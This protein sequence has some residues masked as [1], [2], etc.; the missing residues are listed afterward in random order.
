MSIESL[1]SII[2]RGQPTDLDR[3]TLADR[4]REAVEGLFST[5]YH[6]RSR[7]AARVA[8]MPGADAVSFAGLVH[9]DSPT[10]GV[11]GGMSLV[12]FPVEGDGERAAGSLLTFVC[13]TRGLAPDE[14]I[15]G[16]PGHA[17]HLQALRRF[18]GKEHGA[19]AWVKH[20]PT[21]LAEPF[22]N[23]AEPQPRLPPH[24]NPPPQGGRGIFWESSSGGLSSN[25]PSPLE[26]EGRGGG[27]G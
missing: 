2:A 20:D 1:A 21:N 27:D 17:R 26:G 25:S 9:E 14:Q 4:T 10:S 23:A 15:L 13:G 6:A 8:L 18:V 16:R 24:P 3:D 22:P 7:Y 19:A 11:Y 5:R 12:W